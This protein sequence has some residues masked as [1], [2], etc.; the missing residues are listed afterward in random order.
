M[1]WTASRSPSARRVFPSSGSGTISFATS[2]GQPARDVAERARGARGV[3]R[4]QLEQLLEVGRAGAAPRPANSSRRASAALVEDSPEQPGEVAALGG[5]VPGEQ[6]IDQRLIA[7]RR[8]AAGRSA[9]DSAEER[10]QP[11][12]QPLGGIVRI[13]DRAQQIAHLPRLVRL[14]ETLLRREHGGDA[15]RRQRVRHRSATRGGCGSA[16]RS[17]AR[18]APRRRGEQRGDLVGDRLAPAA[19]APR[20]SAA[21]PRCRPSPSAASADAHPV[22]RSR[23]RCRRS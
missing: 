7:A 8:A 12:A 20:A 10:R 16:R 22:D 11:G 18:R 1:I 9:S 13:G 14:V 3:H 19:P 23:C 5:G 2:A 21:A 17:P 6:A 4:E 15:A